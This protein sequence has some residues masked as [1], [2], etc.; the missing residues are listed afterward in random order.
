MPPSPSRCSQ[1]ALRGV[2]GEA[3]GGG[4]GGGRLSASIVLEVGIDMDNTEFHGVVS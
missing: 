4:S 1:K 2:D 3:G